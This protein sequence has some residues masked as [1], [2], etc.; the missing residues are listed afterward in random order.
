[1]A[2]RGPWAP[3]LEFCWLCQEYDELPWSHCYKQCEPP[4]QEHICRGCL[5]EIGDQL[6]LSAGITALSAEITAL[7]A[8]IEEIKTMLKSLQGYIQRMGGGHEQTS[9]GRVQ[10]G[11][12]RVL[13]IE[14]F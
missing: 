7:R 11:V 3:C 8:Q 4:H 14:H 6:N 2:H 1:M 12:T 9:P 13:C 5:D 10:N